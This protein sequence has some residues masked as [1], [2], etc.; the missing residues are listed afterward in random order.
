MPLFER[1]ETLE[2][3]SAIADVA[4]LLEVKRLH[5]AHLP[6]GPLRFAKASDEEPLETTWVP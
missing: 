1:L 4:R 6:S 5:A 3:A 2:K